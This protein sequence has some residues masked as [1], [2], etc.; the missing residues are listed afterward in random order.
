M[1]LE[2]DS[3]EHDHAAKWP[4]SGTPRRFEANTPIRE[5]RTNRLNGA[6]GGCRKIRPQPLHLLIGQPEM[7]AH[8]APTVWGLKHDDRGVS[9]QFMGPERKQMIEVVKRL[10][11]V[12]AA[13]QACHCRLATRATRW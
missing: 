8:T 13:D 2:V 9:S 7:I 11:E 4:R 10:N 12:E 1:R 6:L 3:I 5:Q